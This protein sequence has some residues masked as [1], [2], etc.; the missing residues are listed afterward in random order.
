MIQANNPDRKIDGFNV[1]QK[2]HVEK[3]SLP[4]L[5]LELSNT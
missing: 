2:L 5:R 1:E 3:S 4:A